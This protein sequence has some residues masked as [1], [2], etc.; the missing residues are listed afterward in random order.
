[1]NIIVSNDRTLRLTKY[2]SQSTYNLAEIN[3]YI[4]KELQVEEPYVRLTPESSQSN[5][6]IP[7][8]EY[9]AAANYTIFRISPYFGI[10]LSARPYLFS[11]LLSEDA[12]PFAISEAITID[13]IN[14]SAQ[15][16]M[17]MMRS[18]LTQDFSPYGLSDDEEPI[19]I[20]DTRNIMI[21]TNKNVIITGDNVSEMLTFR[22]KKLQE[23]IDLTTKS[24]YFDYIQINDVTKQVWSLPIYSYSQDPQFAD[25][26]R[27][28]VVVPYH[29]TQTAGAL[30]FAIAAV[31]EETLSGG[32]GEEK[33]PYVWQTRPASLTILKGLGRPPVSV[34]PEGD[35]PA[36]TK[37]LEQLEAI[38][39]SDVYE[40]DDHPNDERLV[41]NSGDI[42]EEYK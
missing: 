19:D 37:V 10:K 29:L 26:I 2:S 35:A 20:D 15:A 1:M 28:K 40:L 3:F 42:E 32:E 6:D 22:V 16:R 12:V 5:Y 38:K 27:L 13:A 39:S 17:M 23:G 30:Q 9:G 18:G 31:D 34:T 41:F 21:A 25:C 14:Q 8:V 24:L 11:I 33:T 7:L 4:A 36:L